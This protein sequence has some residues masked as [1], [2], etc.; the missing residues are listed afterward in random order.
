LVA[1][2]ICAAGL[3]PAGATAQAATIEK[4]GEV[5]TAIRDL[6]IG[7]N[8]YD[9]EFTCN[10]STA[11]T[12][13][14]GGSG[15]AP[16]FDFN[17]VASAERATLAIDIVFTVDGGVL[18][19]GCG[20]GE[21]QFS[22]VFSIGYRLTEIEIN[23]PGQSGI[24]E[25]PLLGVCQGTRATPVPPDNTPPAQW[26]NLDDDSC[27]I[28]LYGVSS[29]VARF[30]LGGSGGPG[31]QSPTA[32]A[33]GPYSG[34][35]GSPVQ[36]DGSGSND[37]DGSISS[38]AWEFGDGGTSTLEQPEYTYSSAAEYNVTLTVTDDRDL[39]SSNTTQA[40][41]GQSGAPPVADAGG[42]YNASTGSPVTLD[43]SGSNDPDGSIAS[44]S[45]DMD[46]GSTRKGRKPSHTYGADGKY[47][48]TLTVTNNEGETD[49]DT[50]TVTSAT[51]NQA[52]TADAGGAYAE[53]TGVAV[54]FEG[55]GSEDPDG[56]IASYRWIFEDGSTLKGKRP[57]RTFRTA[58]DYSVNLEVTDEDG[59]VDSDTARVTISD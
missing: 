28:D 22:T 8:T 37:L 42:P 4:D 14:L 2:G 31:N 32:D 59:L 45:W 48:V 39:S 23:P 52:P 51:G 3:L 38:Y 35:V 57:K 40:S 15:V 20:T 53:A 29:V 7:G 43:G 17:D 34:A 56:S 46:D 41:I 18:A 30:S 11:E 19:V 33:G 13:P 54:Q 1:V 24:L 21:G 12:Y 16:V 49:I 6:T 27:D 55:G 10:V 25:L 9:V 47:T 5:A 36:F 44:Y 26:V 50:T 58:G